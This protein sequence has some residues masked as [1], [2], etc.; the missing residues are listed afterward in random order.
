MRIHRYGACGCEAE[1]VNDL[2]ARGARDVLDAHADSQS[3]GVKLGA[4]ALL[5]FI[6]LPGRGGLIGG[7]AAL[8]QD[9][10]W[11]Q[12]SAEGECARGNVAGGGAVVDQRCAL[13]GFEERSDVGCA[14]LKLE[15]RRDAVERLDALA[16]KVLAVLV[17]INEAGCNDEASCGDYATAGQ[18]IRGNAHDFSVAY[19]DVSHSIEAGLGIHDAAAFE[20]EVVLLSGDESGRE[21]EEGEREDQFAHGDSG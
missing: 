19:A 20:D 15:G 9:V 4:Q 12:R 14:D 3:A 17:E 5:H 2:L 13:P 1:D 10:A 6:E 16:G 8:G 18:M 11:G 7:I 21:R